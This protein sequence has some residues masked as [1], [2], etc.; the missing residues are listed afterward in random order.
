[1][2]SLYFDCFSGA[3]GDMILGALFEL[4]LTPEDVTEGITS[5]GVSDFRVSL[6]KVDRAGI[7]SF[8]AVVD[9]PDEKNHRHLS[10]IERM[11]GGSALSPRVKRDATAIFRR[12]GEAEARVHGTE[13]EKVHF[14]EVGAMDSIIDIVGACIGFD[15]LGVEQFGCSKLHVG[16][17]FVEMAHGRFPVPPPAVAELLKGFPI[18]SGD[19]EGELLTPTAAAIISTL[20]TRSGS[21]DGFTVEKTGYGAGDRN[22]PGTPNVVRLMLGS[23]AP[24]VGEVPSGGGRAAGQGSELLVLETN[25]DDVSPEILGYVMETAFEKGALDCWFTPIQMK[26]NR[27]ATLLSLLC[28]PRDRDAFIELLVKETPTLGVRVRSV[29]RIC[30]TREVSVARTKYGEVPVKIAK[31]GDRVTNAKPEHDA[32]KEIAR[33]EGIPLREVEAEVIRSI[34]ST[35]HPPKPAG[36]R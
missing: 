34:E 3:S 8:K 28:E 22:P 10:A 25:L 30:L 14:H 15:K 9:A 18:Y 32:V 12:L 36:T 17:G 2:K 19:I 31:F 33:R 20:C 27:P 35:W 26:K 21:V 16:S 24:F 6:E 1:M 23:A 5:M 13:V 29:E 4:G 11:I 7:S